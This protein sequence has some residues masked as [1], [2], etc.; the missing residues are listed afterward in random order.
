MAHRLLSI[1]PG[2]KPNHVDNIFLNADILHE[3]KQYGE[4]EIKYKT[5]IQL[6]SKQAGFMIQ[7]G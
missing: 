6:C 1:L 5:A 7:Q 2:K 4:A 3:W